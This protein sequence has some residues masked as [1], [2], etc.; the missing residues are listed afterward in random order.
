M[1][2]NA[3]RSDAD[4]AWLLLLIEFRA[5]AARDP[6][7][8][9]RYAALHARTLDA[10]AAVVESVLARGGVTP[11]LPPR[12]L[13]ELIFALDAGTILERAAGSTVLP[14]ARIEELVDRLV[15]PR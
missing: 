11:A 4:R 10:F 7:V 9:R 1:R 3:R 15:T 6:Q 8:N 5:V 2:A 12:E 14:G 13:A